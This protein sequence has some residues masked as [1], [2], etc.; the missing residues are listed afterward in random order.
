M[1]IEITMAQ[2]STV[3]SV[4]DSWCCPLLHCFTLNVTSQSESSE[5]WIFGMRHSHAV[6]VNAV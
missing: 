1:T 5:D 6:C 4:Y 2:R 3:S